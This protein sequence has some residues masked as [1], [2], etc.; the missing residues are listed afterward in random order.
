MTVVEDLHVRLVHEVE[1]MRWRELDRKCTRYWARSSNFEEIVSQV[2]VR[3][4]CMN[5]DS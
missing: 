5:Q 2:H 3:H 1:Q 4:V